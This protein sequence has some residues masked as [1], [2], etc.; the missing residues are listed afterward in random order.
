MGLSWT[1]TLTAC[2]DGAARWGARRRRSRPGVDDLARATDEGAQHAGLLR[3]QSDGCAFAQK[4]LGA[5]CLDARRAFGRWQILRLLEACWN[6]AGA[7]LMPEW[8]ER[9][10]KRSSR[11]PMEGAAWGW[12]GAGAAM[13]PGGLASVAPVGR[14]AAPDSMFS[15]R[16]T[17]DR[18]RAG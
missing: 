10:M 7:T 16:L 2:P 15:Q 17:R 4:T 9:A 1:V 18:G 8:L 5:L 6:P 11:A 14:L 13:A 3:G 12:K